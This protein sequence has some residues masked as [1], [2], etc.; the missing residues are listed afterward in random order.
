MALLYIA[1]VAGGG[2]DTAFAQHLLR[3]LLQP[4]PGGSDICVFL[5][6]CSQAAADGFAAARAILQADSGIHPRLQ[7]VR[8]F[9][10]GAGDR[11]HALSGWR[12]AEGA[13]SGRLADAPGP[14]VDDI[15]AVLQG[16]LRCFDSGAHAVT[17]C[18]GPSGFSSSDG[19]EP[20]HACARA[21]PLITVREFGQ[22]AFCRPP[23]VAWTPASTGELDASAGL[24]TGRGLLVGLHS[25]AAAAAPQATHEI[26]LAGG[27]LGIFDIPMPHGAMR[28]RCHLVDPGLGPAR[29]AELAVVPTAAGVGV[30]TAAGV[31]GGSARSA[32]SAVPYVVGYF[33]TDRHARQLGRLVACHGIMTCAIGEKD[34]T[35]SPDS[36]RSATRAIGSVA[37]LLPSTSATA[38]RAFKQG[39]QDVLADAVVEAGAD[40]VSGQLLSWLFSASESCGATVR[41]GSVAADATASCSVVQQGA[42]HRLNVPALGLVIIVADIHACKLPNAQFRQLLAG[43]AAAVVTG[44]AT[45]N[46]VLCCN[47]ENASAVFG[48][49]LTT[50][51]IAL[52]AGVESALCSC[53]SDA[54][55]EPLSLAVAGATAQTYEIS[56]RSDMLVATSGVPFWYSAEPH[57]RAVELDLKAA[58]QTRAAEGSVAPSVASPSVLA[59]RAPLA[60]AAAQVV[61]QLWKALETPAVV[62]SA[63]VAEAGIGSAMA[64]A[65][66]SLISLLAYVNAPMQPAIAALARSVQVFYEAYQ[67]A[68]A[69]GSAS[70]GV[71][72]GSDCLN[73]AGTAPPG[74]AWASVQRAFGVCCA[75]LCQQHAHLGSRVLA[76]VQAALEHKTGTAV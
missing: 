44:D 46:E 16:P 17:Q 12:T 73:S 58:V 36:S 32:D 10:R 45:L 65:D 56:G 74:A 38:M 50:S 52:S 39:L 25:G 59:E 68:S 1:T 72:D 34:G 64:E 5:A 8:V 54:A 13:L 35:S 33:R 20:G 49:K 14:S 23:S 4:P 21:V 11:V 31:E 76:L 48:D 55:E 62:T 24:A 6:I 30:A 22:A 2:G 43:A 69:A 27:E 66:P 47:D 42:T 70:V 41:T 67:A 53:S 61:A 28:A 9:E 18:V 75:S 26:P 19:A 37:V 15:G 71:R 63:A 3:S 57:K 51:G 29:T 40:H 7:A 60:S